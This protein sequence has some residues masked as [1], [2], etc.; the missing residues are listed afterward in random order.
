[1]LSRLHF[2]LQ[3]PGDISSKSK[4]I[5]VQRNSGGQAGS[6][7]Q[8]LAGSCW[9]A[10]AGGQLLAGSFW[11][12]ASGG[13]LLAGS[14]WRAASGGQLLAGSFWRA[15]SGRQLLVGRKTERHTAKLIP[16]VMCC[17]RMEL[18]RPLGQERCHNDPVVQMQR[19]VA[20]YEAGLNR[21][22]RQRVK[23]RAPEWAFEVTRMKNF[24]TT[25]REQLRLNQDIANRSSETETDRRLDQLRVAQITTKFD[26]LGFNLRPT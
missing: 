18:Q 3:F 20:N 17:C 24:L 12:A 1:M 16:F 25:A 21:L 2:R 9:R 8:L 7:G 6:G 10:A 15:A 11:R 14:F 13:Q 23:D 5:N 4:I 26:K 19:R 22:Y